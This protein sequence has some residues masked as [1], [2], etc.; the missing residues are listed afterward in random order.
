MTSESKPKW[1]Y[2]KD[3]LSGAEYISLSNEYKPRFSGTKVLREGLL[4]DLNV[5]GEI[6]GI[7]ILTTDKQQ[8]S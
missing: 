4:I 8:E 7:E 3:N 1:V 6:V 2:T 5:E